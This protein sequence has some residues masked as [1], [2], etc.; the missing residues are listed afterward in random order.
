[1][2]NINNEEWWDDKQSFQAN[3]TNKETAKK[4]LE[5]LAHEI[6]KKVNGKLIELKIVPNSQNSLNRDRKDLTQEDKELYKDFY[7]EPIAFYFKKFEYEYKNIKC[8]GTLLGAEKKYGKFLSKDKVNLIKYHGDIEIYFKSKYILIKL[9]G[10][11]RIISSVE[12]ITKES[13][14]FLF[15]INLLIYPD[16]IPSMSSIKSE[17]ST[18]HPQTIL[19]F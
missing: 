18:L 4:N 1:M 17:Y 14:Q 16:F 8:T 6:N 19:I 2:T 9:G 11:N 12:F 7:N 3:E 15:E 13:A 5:N 10:K